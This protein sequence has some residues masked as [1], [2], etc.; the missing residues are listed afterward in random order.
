M[1]SAEA[2][3]DYTVGDVIA[4][5]RY[6]RAEHELDRALDLDALAPEMWAA[7]GFARRVAREATL[8]AE[9]IEARAMRIERGE[10]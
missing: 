7:A 3:T 1:P 4:C 2:T 6:H 9:R 10:R 5:K 8:L